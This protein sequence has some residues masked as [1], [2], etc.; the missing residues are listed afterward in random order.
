MPRSEECIVLH[1]E[2]DDGMAYLFRM[3][4]QNIDATIELYRVAD[5]EEAAK[6][7]SRARPYDDA[8]IPDLIVLDL[9]L[10][11][12]SGFDVLHDI[13]RL[14][15]LESVPVFVVTSSGRE[16]DQQRALALGATGVFQKP[17]NFNTLALVAE[18]IWSA[19]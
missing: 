18:Q 19:I 4:L 7:L 10:P 13:R 6:F 15:H 3:A 2:D 11:R 8:P 1:V 16:S 9:N 12:K 5:G 14:P 17:D